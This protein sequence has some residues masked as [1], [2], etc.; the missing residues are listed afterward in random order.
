MNRGPQSPAYSLCY[1]TKKT[2]H[3]CNVASSYIH[4]L[5]HDHFLCRYKRRKQIDK[6]ETKSKMSSGED[7]DAGG[8]DDDDDDDDDDGDDDDDPIMQ[9]L[10]DLST[11]APLTRDSI[12]IVSETLND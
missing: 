9:E 3:V 4:C 12:R 6:T 7:G 5:I 8:D 11:F 10:F 1:I 2:P